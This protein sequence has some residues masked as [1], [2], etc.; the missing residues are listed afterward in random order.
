MGTSFDE[1]NDPLNKGRDNSSLS[2]NPGNCNRYLIVDK[3]V[4]AKTKKFEYF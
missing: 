1:T 2:S 3:I 4:F